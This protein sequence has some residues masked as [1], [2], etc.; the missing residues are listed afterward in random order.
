M[1]WESIK[2]FFG[3]TSTKSK[4]N[5]PENRDTIGQH[6]QSI[7]KVAISRYENNNWLSH[8]STIHGLNDTLIL[9]NQ[10]RKIGPEEKEEAYWILRT[11]KNKHPK[12][13]KDLQ[14]HDE[15]L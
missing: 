5:E 14:I 15:E 4:Y 2:K 10:S 11:F 7:C 12:I 13:F 8:S 1:N 9:L 6:L 3:W